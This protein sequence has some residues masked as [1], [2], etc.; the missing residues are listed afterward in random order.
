MNR[1]HFLSTAPAALL[2]AHGAAHAATKAAP[3]KKGVM[4]MNRIGPSQSELY[5]AN[6]DGSNERKLLQ[7][8]VFD[9]HASPS[10]DG[11]WVVFTSERGGLGNAD[12]YR[13]KADG[14]GAAAQGLDQIGPPLRRRNREIAAHAIAHQYNRRT[15][16]GDG[17]FKPTG[18]VVGE[19]EAALGLARPA[20]VQQQ[21]PDALGREPAE[22][23]VPLHQVQ[24]VSAIDQAGHEQHHGPIGGPQPVVQQ[25]AA[26]LSPDM[27]WF[28]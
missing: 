12:L 18:D 15:Y 8:S 7:Q 21:R 24:D 2:L 14:A 28:Q 9:Y 4:L 13:A 11:K 5:I 1:R 22:H 6:A 26:A 17:P 10:A 27:R 23:R 19:G 25:A 16:R 3:K 20:P